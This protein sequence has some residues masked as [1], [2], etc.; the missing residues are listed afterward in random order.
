ML[1]TRITQRPKIPRALKRDS[2]LV[3]P[4]AD[5]ALVFDLVRSPGSNVAKNK[6]AMIAEALASTRTR[7]RRL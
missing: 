7:K 5:P 4:W 1:G 2:D 3:V 6:D